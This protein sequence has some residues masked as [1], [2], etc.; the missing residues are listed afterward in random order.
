MLFDLSFASWYNRWNESILLHTFEHGSCPELNVMREQLIYREVVIKKLRRI[1][2]LISD[3][4]S[5]HIVVRNH[6]T[7]KTTVVRQ[8]ARDVGKVVIY[9]VDVL[10]VELGL[11][12]GRVNSSK[13]SQEFF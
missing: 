8:Y 10:P 3:H 5:Y 6:R 13:T 9:V 7:G 12:S 2:E 4:S 1:F 11:E